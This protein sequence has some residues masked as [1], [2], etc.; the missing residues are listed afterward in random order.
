MIEKK[1]IILNRLKERYQ[2]APDGTVTNKRTGRVLQYVKTNYR[3]EIVCF[4]DIETKKN[5][6]YT[7]MQL[8]SFLN[9]DYKK[10]HKCKICNCMTEDFWCIKC[11]MKMKN[12]RREIN[13]RMERFYE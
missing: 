8:Q 9:G 11:K 12:I 2:I 3:Y 4:W 10:I 6:H 7:K 1:Y 13:K 5:Y